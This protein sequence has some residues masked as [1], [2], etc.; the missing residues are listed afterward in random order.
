MNDKTQEEGK[1]SGIQKVNGEYTSRTN[2][3]QE[4]HHRLFTI[5][6]DLLPQYGTNWHKHGLATLKTEALARILYYNELY[7]KIVDVPGVVCEFG[8]QWGATLAQLI[9]LRNIYEP[10]NASRVIYGFDTF[11]G[12]IS[13]SEKDGGFS[14]NG[15]YSSTGGYES[16][17]EEIL[18]LHESFSP[19]PQIKKYELIKG[20]ASVTVEGWLRN[21]P[22]AIIS[23]AIFDMD[24]YEPT[25]EV[26]KK[27]TPRLTKG[28]LLV[29]D[30][31]NCKHFPGE[32][33]ALDEIVGINNVR[34]YRTPLQPYCAWAIYG[35]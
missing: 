1:V 17:L 12:F 32:T 13:T 27:I 21:N 3:A 6:K 26:L 28:S 18:F 34:L 20:D 7:K 2:E 29:F 24:L 4:R 11:E 19:M 16:L 25:K 23:M 14:N 33:S 10:F 15:D 35:E 30:E 31:L 9:N 22:H 5:A 8:V